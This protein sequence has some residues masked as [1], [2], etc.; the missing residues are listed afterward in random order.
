M[1]A[2][3]P[4]APTTPC[5]MAKSNTAAEDEPELLTTAEVPAAP[6]VVVPTAIVAAVPVAPVGPVGPVAPTGPILAEATI[7]TTPEVTTPT[8]AVPNLTV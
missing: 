3:V 4:V 5:G 1:V 7:V 8:V 6:V 2:A